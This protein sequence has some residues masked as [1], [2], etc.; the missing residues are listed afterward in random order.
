[1]QI[2]EGEVFEKPFDLPDA[3]AS[4]ERGKNLER[5]LRYSSALFVRQWV[6]CLHIVQTVGQFY[7]HNT[8]VVRHR[9]KHFSHR[10]GG[11]GPFYRLSV[12]M[13]RNYVHIHFCDTFNESDNGLS[14]FG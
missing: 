2:L 7:N 4:G 8:E 1:M 5:L 13:C 9:E 11:S 6:E 14:K 3:Q 12:L 10:F